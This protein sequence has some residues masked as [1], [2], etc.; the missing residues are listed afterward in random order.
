MVIRIFILKNR[1][2]FVTLRRHGSKINCNKRH[3]GQ[4]WKGNSLASLM[5]RVTTTFR[6]PKYNFLDTFA[7][8][9]QPLEIQGGLSD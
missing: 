7:P 6:T 4:R 1:N 5:I 2:R 8:L 3:E 9:M